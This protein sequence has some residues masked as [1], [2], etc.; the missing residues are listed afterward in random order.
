MD[1]YVIRHA[2]ALA[3][4]E[5][6]ITQDADRPLSGKGEKQA[7]ALA[8]G[9]QGHGVKL[10][11][12]LTSP[13]L[14]A[15]Q[16]AEGMLRHWSSPA[17]E[18]KTCAELAPGVKPRALARVLNNLREESVALVGHQPDL[19]AWTAWLIGSKKAQV[20]FAK[21]GT[22][23]IACGGEVRKGAGMLVWLIT[24]AWL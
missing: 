19:S 14:R 1:L 20:D 8:R 11:L 23:H 17:P 21:A 13:L 2:D 6:N 15:R 18:L 12:V 16:T 5:R 4:G 9:L 22:A 7:T 24:P 10:D 3:L